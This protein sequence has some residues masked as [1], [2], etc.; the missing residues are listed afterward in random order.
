VVE[1]EGTLGCGKPCQEK[2]QYIDYKLIIYLTSQ[3]QN[4]SRTKV[5]S[6]ALSFVFAFVGVFSPTKIGELNPRAVVGGL[7]L[8]PAL[9][10]TRAQKVVRSVDAPH[11]GG[12]GQNGYIIHKN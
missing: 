3:N 10:P 12:G 9:T 11:G 5:I 2:L 7:Y 1:R 4:E 8:L 6:P